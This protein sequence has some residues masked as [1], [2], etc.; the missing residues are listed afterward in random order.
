MLQLLPHRL[1]R[2]AADPGIDLVEYQ[3]A[4]V[5][6]AAAGIAGGQGHA[7]QREHHPRQ[8]SAG[9]DL[10]HGLQRLTGVGRDQVRHGVRPCGAPVRFALTAR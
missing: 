10:L 6:A 3:G 2:A 1:G 7:F 8:L 9:G 5:L 4:L